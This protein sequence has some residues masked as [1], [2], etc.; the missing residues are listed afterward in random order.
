VTHVNGE[1]SGAG[2]VRST[3]FIGGAPGELVPLSGRERGAQLLV[4]RRHELVAKEYSPQDRSE[5]SA[6]VSELPGPRR[7]RVARFW[8]ESQ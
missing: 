1:F 2:W 6:G 8:D 4:I 5:W 3:T 7:T